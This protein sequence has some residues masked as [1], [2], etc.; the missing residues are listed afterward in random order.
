MPRFQ[1][2][3]DNKVMHVSLA[4]HIGCIDSALWYWLDVHQIIFSQFE[5]LKSSLWNKFVKKRLHVVA[6]A[7]GW[8]WQLMCSPLDENVSFHFSWV[9]KVYHLTCAWAHHFQPN[10]WLLA[11]DNDEELRRDATWQAIS[12]NIMR[13]F[14]CCF[15]S[16]QFSAFVHFCWQIHTIYVVSV[17]I[18]RLDLINCGSSP[19]FQLALFKNILLAW[20]YSARFTVCEFNICDFVWRMPKIEEYNRVPIRISAY[21]IHWI[22]MALTVSIYLNVNCEWQNKKRASEGERE[23][24][25]MRLRENM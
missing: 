10:H 18:S 14:S 1:K 20:V 13:N 21:W 4:Y 9:I 3:F 16:N 23:V 6:W 15:F 2:F 25:A 19:P 17:P 8:Y 24:N 22:Q 12:S 11:V 7:D 5:S